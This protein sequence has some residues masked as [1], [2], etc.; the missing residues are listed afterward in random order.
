MYTKEEMK[1]LMYWA[2][3][4][5]NEHRKHPQFAPLYSEKVIDKKIDKLDKKKLEECSHPE[6]SRHGTGYLECQYCMD[7][8]EQLI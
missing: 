1:T 4:Y 2:M 3:C 7:C 5:G 6:H 8:G